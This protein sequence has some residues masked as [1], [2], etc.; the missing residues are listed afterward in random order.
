M[1]R[2]VCWTH[3]Q[4]VRQV[5]QLEAVQQQLQVPQ[6][7]ESGDRRDTMTDGPNHSAQPRPRFTSANTDGLLEAHHQ[8]GKMLVR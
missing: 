4:D 5:T 7:G 3:G 2:C 1:A 6:L 8:R